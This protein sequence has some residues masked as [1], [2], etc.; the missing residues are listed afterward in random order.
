MATDVDSLAMSDSDDGQALA[1]EPVKPRVQSAARAVGVLLE[2]AKSDNG[3]TTKEISERVGMGRQATYHLLH[4]LV[5]AGVLR[6]AD[7]S[8]YLLGLRVGT[9]AEGFAR[10]LAPSEHLAPLVRDLARTTGETA[11]ASGWWADEIAVLT[12]TRGS[13][14]VSAAEVSQGH[15][16]EAHARASG[17]L[18]LAYA[19]P[20]VR[21]R[22]LDSHEIRAITP[23]TLTDRA[24]IDAE[25]DLIGR[26]GFS[27][28]N[29]EFAAGLCCLAVPLDEG[30]SPFA[31]SISAPRERYLAHRESYLAAL[32]RA[33]DLGAVSTAA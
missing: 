31:I 6:R 20:G 23:N 2:V 29:E 9:L 24:A 16:G 19:P 4:T 3:L 11:Y 32:R 27:E 18:L 25:L 17:K 1:K 8:R 28:D 12:I 13:N 10:Q 14:P 22:Y 26:Q 7:R 21:R 5:G 30:L 15:I 33:A